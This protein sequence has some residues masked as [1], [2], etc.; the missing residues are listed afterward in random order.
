MRLSLF[1]N[2]NDTNTFK[3]I[4]QSWAVIALLSDVIIVTLLWK[5]PTIVRHQTLREK[6]LLP[7][8]RLHEKSETSW[9]GRKKR[10]YERRLLPEPMALRKRVV[11]F[12]I[13]S[14]CFGGYIDS[15]GFSQVN[16]QQIARP[17]TGINIEFLSMR[18]EL[19]VRHCTSARRDNSVQFSDNP[20]V[21]SHRQLHFIHLC[22][23]GFTIQR[24]F[25]QIG[26]R[27]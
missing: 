22:R 20:I 19:L 21:Y 25:T 26:N 7:A 4:S 27:L 14:E 15:L 24:A 1:Q 2:N 9:Q 18:K 17:H 13:L 23:N 10:P 6:P 12:C 5:C 11:R 3:S 8:G 16:K